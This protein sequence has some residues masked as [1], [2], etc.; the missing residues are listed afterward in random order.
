MAGRPGGFELLSAGGYYGWVRHPFE[1]FDTDELI[2]RLLIQQGVLAIPGTAFMPDDEQLVRFSF[3][4]ATTI[5][6]D[7][8]GDRLSDF[9]PAGP[10]PG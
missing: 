6:L 2:R 10:A 4:N 8:L 5:E 1:G 7:S 9:E 3:A